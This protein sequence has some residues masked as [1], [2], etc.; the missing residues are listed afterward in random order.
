[1]IARV[2]PP[3]KAESDRLKAVAAIPCIPHMIDGWPAIPAQVQH[4]LEGGV[5]L[6]DFHTYAS[7][8]WHHQGLCTGSIEAATKE[9]GPS[10]AHNKPAFAER[11]GT[12]AQLVQ[13]TDAILR[14]QRREAEQGVYLPYLEMMGLTQQL[15]REIVLG[16][17]PA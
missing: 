16:K 3:T 8:P 11:Y 6:G 1:M 7:C 2:K 13:I 15:H 5:R 9:Q 4:T 14:M 17:S 10:F 12:E